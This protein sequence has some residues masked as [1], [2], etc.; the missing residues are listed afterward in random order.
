[1]RSEVVTRGAVG[2]Q[3]LGRAAVVAA[4][5]LELGVLVERVDL[6]GADVKLLLEQLQVERAVLAEVA[7][8]VRV[9]EA[10]DDRVDRLLQVAQARDDLAAPLAHLRRDV[11]RLVEILVDVHSKVDHV[12]LLQQGNLGLEDVLLGVDALVLEELQEREDQVPV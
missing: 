11:L 10:G 4:V 2:L 3:Q 6:L 1:M 8:H 7:D 5:E 12:C 9:G